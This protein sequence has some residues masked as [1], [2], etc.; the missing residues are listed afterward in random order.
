[1]NMTSTDILIFQTT[2]STPEDVVRIT[3]HLDGIPGI[4]R[5]TIDLEDIDNV[6]RIEANSLHPRQVTA[7]THNAGYHCEELTD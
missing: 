3:P 2:V 7:I 6:L 5:W 4:L 1:M